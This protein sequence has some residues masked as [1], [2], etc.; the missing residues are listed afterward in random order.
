MIDRYYKECDN[1]SLSVIMDSQGNY[2][3]KVIASVTDAVKCI[4]SSNEY[5]K[6]LEIV[7]SESLKMISFTITEKGYALTSINSN[8]LKV[9]QH[10]IDCG[11]D[12][13][14][15]TMGIVTALLYERYKM[16]LIQ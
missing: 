4:R 9:V 8:Y 14:M 3:K 13:A 12:E 1:L 7:C 6:L 5:K 2:H 15:H 10:D 11:P 16:E